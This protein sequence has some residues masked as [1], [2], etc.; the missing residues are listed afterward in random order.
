MTTKGNE[1]VSLDAVLLGEFL[2]FARIRVD[3]PELL[4]HSY[5][6]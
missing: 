6:S 5:I 3:K 1:S 4:S 2:L